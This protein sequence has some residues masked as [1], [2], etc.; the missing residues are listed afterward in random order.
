[1]KILIVDDEELSLT[2]VRRV[3][4]WRGMRNVEICD[5]G[6][7][8]IKKIREGNFDVV[9]LDL[10]MPEVDGMQVLEAVR[11]FC[12]RTEF[13]ILT[14]VDDVAT[15]VKAMRRGA[16]DYLVKP[17]DNELLFLSIERP[18]NTRGSWRGFPP[19]QVL[20]QVEFRLPLPIRSHKARR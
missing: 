10:L 1:M 5:A 8:A 18:M 14:A 11:P 12:P 15:T 20:T 9:L 2:S 3:L 6:R 19:M 13:I 7:E 17:V 16:Y 4:K